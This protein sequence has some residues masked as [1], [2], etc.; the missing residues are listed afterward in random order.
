MENLYRMRFE[1]A[2][3]PRQSQELWLEPVVAIVVIA[4]KNRLHLLV[5]FKDVRSPESCRSDFQLAGNMSFV[6]LVAICIVKDRQK[7]MHLR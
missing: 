7:V 5:P 1:L 3:P 2:S 6:N 4:D